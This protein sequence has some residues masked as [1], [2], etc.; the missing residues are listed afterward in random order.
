MDAGRY[1]GTM[2]FRQSNRTLKTGIQQM[3]YEA[4][5]AEG[6]NS[7]DFFCLEDKSEYLQTDGLNDVCSRRGHN[8]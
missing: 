4:E 2:Y 3:K 7:F 6:C 1:D 8:I 5:S